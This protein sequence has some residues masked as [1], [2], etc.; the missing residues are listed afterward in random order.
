MAQFLISTVVHF[1]VDIRIA[2]DKNFNKEIYQDLI[3]FE[4]A[5]G[6]RRHELEVIT[7]EDILWRGSTLVVRVKQGKGGKYREATVIK[8]MEDRVLEI[9]QNKEPSKPI[10]SKIPKVMDVHSYRALY[11]NIR[12]CQDEERK[13]TQDLGHNRVEVLRGHYIRKS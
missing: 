6:L 8:G 4:T 2:M 10:F 13:V 1:L 3:D 12:L 9:I 11:A 5:T 7:P